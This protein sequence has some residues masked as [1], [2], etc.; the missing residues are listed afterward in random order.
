M[1]ATREVKVG[2]F[3]FIA[4]VLLTVIVFSISD[5]YGFSPGYHLKVLFHSAGGIGVGAP[6]RLA[7]VDVGEVRKVT[8]SFDESQ[9]MTRAELFIWLRDNVKI[10]EDAT[11]YVNTS[12]LIGEKYLEVIPGSREAHILKDGEELR[13]RDTVAMADFMNTGYEVVAQLNKTI[14]AVHSVVGDE[15]VRAAFKG[16]VTNSEEVTAKLNTMLD[17]TN[18]I[19]ESIRYGKGTVGRFLMEDEIYRDVQD[20]VKDVKAH[21]WKLFFRGR[22]SKK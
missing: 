17:H 4:F 22:E 9:A 16:T 10:E 14:A 3:V 1:Q 8:V 18:A 13:G 5:F 15:Q 19:L 2:L 6:V 7:G 21:P 12:G 20:T 11:A